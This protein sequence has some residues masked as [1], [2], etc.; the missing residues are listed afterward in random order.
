MIIKNCDSCPQELFDCN[1]SLKNDYLTKQTNHKVKSDCYAHDEVKKKLKT[2]YNRKC[3]YCDSKVGGTS[4]LHI[5]HYRPKSIYYWLA[6]DWD[7]LIYSCQICNVSKGTKFPTTNFNV[8]N[9]NGDYSQENPLILNPKNNDLIDFYKFDIDGK[10]SENN[11]K[12][13]SKITIKSCKL[14]RD[15]LI[16]DRKELLDNFIQI[17]LISS[18]K[19]DYENLKNKFKL[20][21][22]HQL[23]SNNQYSLMFQYFLLNFDVIFDELYR[24]I[25]NKYLK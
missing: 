16:K 7:N 6:Y 2:I 18:D 13:E 21:F 10:I 20:I 17:V 8:I 25:D 15:D 11:N 23:N 4:Y 1:K 14:N 22:T 3:A 19:K 12:E 24:K 9:H 5:E